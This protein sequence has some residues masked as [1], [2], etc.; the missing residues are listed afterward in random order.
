MTACSARSWRRR[1]KARPS[2]N[3]SP[4]GPCED[5]HL[6]TRRRWVL[7][8]A[9]TLVAALVPA[10]IGGAGGL[11]VDF[12]EVFVAKTA[13]EMLDGGGWM[14]PTFRGEPRVNK[15]P[16]GYWLVMATDVV[17]G[18]DGRVTVGEARFP[19]AV[20]GVVLVLATLAIGAAV[21]DITTAA[22]GAVM[23]SGC[24]GF[25]EYSGSARPDMLY[26][27]ANAVA[28][29]AILWSVKLMLLHGDAVR[30]RRFGWLAAGALVVATMVKGPYLPLVT[31]GS[32]AL[33]LAVSGRRRLILR[34]I[35]PHITLP[36]VIL[37][38]IAWC[39]WVY[40]RLP[41]EAIAS[42]STE[43]GARVQPDELPW[44]RWPD[45][46]YVYNTAKLVVPWVFIYPFIFFVI[47]SK[48]LR[49][50]A[51]VR[52]LWTC[53]VVGLLAWQVLPGR[54][55]HYTLPL[56]AVV[57]PL[58]AITAVDIGLNLLEAGRQRL[59]AW[60]GVA[61]A[62]TLGAVAV[63][64]YMVLDPIRRP[65]LPGVLVVA[66]VSLGA[67]IAMSRGTHPLSGRAKLIP[68]IVA[69][70]CWLLALVLSLNG[71]WWSTENEAVR[72]LAQ[73]LLELRP[74]GQEL[75]AVNGD[76][77]EEEFY[78]HRTIPSVSDVG[79]LAMRGRFIPHFYVLTTRDHWRAPDGYVTREMQWC[80]DPVVLA[81]L[82]A[83]LY[84]VFA[85]PGS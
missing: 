11:A 73:H 83:H 5:E 20:A 46:Y 80:D 17:H 67:A 3:E 8:I 85:T 30:T 15:P 71:S 14:M 77:F 12:H 48:R 10:W 43:L 74:D 81:Q 63:V 18:A 33:Y 29:A 34:A 82:D 47:M 57:C 4:R 75:I 25:I 35:R 37:P 23:L 66:A 45:P 36:A 7:A 24:T 6:R 1:R 51:G 79:A 59:W 55:S 68:A 58:M 78:M 61:T 27:A 70:P 41:T 28:L 50:D 39:G 38:F 54:R 16:L 31:L 62:V 13:E 53:M 56:L 64:V 22:L 84:H 49:G 72:Q 21:T 65:P 52:L 26:A 42:W 76:W 19:S 2:V 9:L 44:W 69:A 60:I 32:V 40:W